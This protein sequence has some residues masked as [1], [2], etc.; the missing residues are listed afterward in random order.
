M[1]GLAVMGRSLALNMADHGY[2]VGGYNRSYAVTEHML[3]AWPHENFTGYST[4]EELVASLEKPR[5]VMLMVKAGKAVDAIIEQLIPLLEQG[6]IILDGGNSFFEDTIRREAYLKGRDCIISVWVSPEVRMV[7][8]L[9]RASCP[10]ETKQPMRKSVRFWRLS[11][12]GQRMAH[13]A[14]PTLEKMV[15]DIM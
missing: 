2:K 3:E 8:A 5:K 7:R 9:D 4:L 10:E 14:A 12:H 1:V 15:P 6:D 11:Q 13:P